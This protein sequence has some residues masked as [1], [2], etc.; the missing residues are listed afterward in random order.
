[1]YARLTVDMEPV[2]MEVDLN[3]HNNRNEFKNRKEKI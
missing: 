3:K 2:N 1:M